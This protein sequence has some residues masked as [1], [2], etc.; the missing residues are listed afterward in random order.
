ME[1]QETKTSDMPLYR[2]VY[3]VVLDR[4]ITGE[5][6][7]G[8]ML[9]SETD[10][11]TE[12]GVSQGTAR[13]ALSELVQA[14]ILDR[15]QG[16]GTF[17]ATTT[18]E[19][20]LFHFF[21]LRNP[22]GSMAIPSLVSEQFSKRRI[23]AKERHLFPA[24][25]DQVYEISRLRCI[26]KVLAAYE[27]IYLP[28]NLFPGLAERAPM[29]NALYPFYHQVYGIPIARADESLTAGIAVREDAERLK[30]ALGTPLLV[31]ERKAYDLSNRLIE[32]RYSKYLTGKFHYEITLK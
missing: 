30:I 6:G 26:E 3:Q 25:E 10:L 29:P 27:I 23:R 21:R 19:N 12:L 8:A 18:P 13:K 32:L 11:G 2:H 17:V 24:G 7:P 22:N 1:L 4:I 14:G 31:V 16:R 9:P 28:A 15:Q 5:L 20:A